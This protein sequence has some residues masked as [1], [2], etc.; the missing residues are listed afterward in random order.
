[1]L[2]HFFIS[3][4]MFL[5]H[6]C[7]AYVVVRGVV[8]LSIWVILRFMCIGL[9][10]ALLAISGWCLVVLLHSFLSSAIRPICLST[11]RDIVGL[12]CVGGVACIVSWWLH[13]PYGGSDVVV[14]VY[15]CH[16]L[17]SFVVY[18]AGG[19]VVVM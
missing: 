5:K 19:R 16:Y 4:P 2:L 11:A 7:C 13:W 10:S 14:C 18:M 9:R 17:G 1:M 6:W 15:D 3:V 8:G 12:R